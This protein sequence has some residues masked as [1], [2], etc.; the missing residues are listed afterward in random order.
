M[1][2][3][4]RAF[5]KQA[6][7]VSALATTAISAAG[8]TQNATAGCGGMISPPATGSIADL[9]RID[10]LTLEYKVGSRCCW[11]CTDRIVSHYQPVALIEVMRGGGDSVVSDAGFKSPYLATHVDT[12]N[13]LTHDVRIWELTDGIIDPAMAFQG[14]KLCGIDAAKRR[15]TL[16]NLTSS[17]SCGDAGSLFTAMQDMM[18]S[19]LPSC[20][21]K[22]VYDTSLDI[23]WRLGCNDVGFRNQI[24]DDICRSGGGNSLIG[25]LLGKED[26]CIGEWAAMK[27]R[28]MAIV[29]NDPRLSSAITAVRAV[30][31]ARSYGLFKFDNTVAKCRIQPVYPVAGT[32]HNPGSDEATEQVFCNEVNDDGRYAYVWWVP[33][34]CCKSITAIKGLCLP[35]ICL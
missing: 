9:L 4:R 24:T 34:T 3:D 11:Y 22:L 7:Q 17:T 18:S 13:F 19:I 30:S 32:G 29:R 27:P 33:V 2:L 28:Q 35:E 16:N 5:L 12:R 6:A 21:P 14:C 1:I 20:F 25:S 8:M 15:G 23:T 31:L 10:P 26:D